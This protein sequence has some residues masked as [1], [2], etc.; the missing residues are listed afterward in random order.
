MAIQF[1][2]EYVKMDEEYGDC[3]YKMF[4]PTLL[5]YPMDVNSSRLYM[6]TS[7]IKQTLS[8]LN[9]D[10]PRIMTGFENTMGKYNKAFKKIEGEWKVI[11]KILKFK[12]GN[13]YSLIIYNEEADTYDIVEKLLAENLTEKFGFMYNTDRID[14][15]KVGD[16]IKDEIIYKTTSYDE[17]MNYMFG[18]NAKVYYST[19]NDTLEDAITIRKS[20]ADNVKSVEVDVVQVSINDND[21]L[22]NLYGDDNEYKTFPNIGEPIENSTVCA[23]RRINKEHLLYDFQSQNMREICNTD[24]DYFV[25]KNSYIYDME[26]YYNGDKPFP[27]NLFYRQIKEYYGDICSYADRIYEWTRRIKNSGSKF[28]QNVTF[29]KSKYQNFNNPEYKWKNKDKAFNHLMV[30]FKVKSIVGLDPGSK[31]TGR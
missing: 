23:T 10:V 31:I 17:N 12:S 27:D 4:G 20:W 30:E 19:S 29:F 2:D 24:V 6:F 26:I 7:N 1:K 21:I 13:L 25:S 22:L 14:S 8:L 11:D 15:L 28:T 9:P 3:L 18:K 5:S 16:T